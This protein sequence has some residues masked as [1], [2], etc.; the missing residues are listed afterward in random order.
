MPTTKKDELQNQ[1]NPPAQQMTVPTQSSTVQ[2]AQN[3]L[4]QQLSG[5][6]YQSPWQPK[7]NDMMTQ[8]LNRDKF[9]YDLNADALY[10]QLREQYALMGQQAMMDTMGQAAM[11]TGGYGNSYAQSVGQQA[12]QGY[13]QLLS[14]KVPDLYQLALNQYLSEGEK[15]Q[16]DIGMMMQQDS[17]DYGKYRDQIADQDDAYSKLV[18]LMTN[19][20]YMPTKD[21]MAYAGMSD[22]QMRAIMGIPDAV[23]TGG[24]RGAGGSGGGSGSYD[25]HNYT[26]EEIK[27]LQ[28][29]AGITPDGVWGPDTQ[30]AYDDGWRPDGKADGTG[31]PPGDTT[32]FTGTTYSEGVAYMEAN[33][34]PPGEA[35]GMMTHAEWQRRKNSYLSSGQ[36]GAEVKNYDSYTDYIKD[37]VEYK[38]SDPL[39]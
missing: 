1:Q 38:T 17:M 24:G 27:K 5:R 19:Y 33:G 13:M 32:G 18:A 20:G 23:T 31:D 37:Y 11:L 29:Q 34:V 4:Q 39:K 2:Q 14:D 12:Y 35:S 6:T 22:A 10:N 25:T 16:S 3:M 9:T 15:M 7:I 30:A 8:Y 26:P 28:E 21:E 36:G